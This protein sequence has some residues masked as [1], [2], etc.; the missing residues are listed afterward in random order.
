MRWK[1]DVCHSHVSLTIKCLCSYYYHAF[2]DWYIAKKNNKV[3]SLSDIW[4][5]GSALVLSST[6][7]KALRVS[8]GTEPPA[9]CHLWLW[10][11]K[12]FIIAASN[13]DPNKGP[14]DSRN[15]THL[16]VEMTPTGAVGFVWHKTV[17]V[18][19]CVVWEL[20]SKVC[21]C[22]QCSGGRGR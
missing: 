10:T 6:R 19:V 13:W 2:V 9:T 4:Y 1:T 5:F 14:G 22:L 15:K 11:K 3:V 21:G 17:C 18:C 7:W 20:E 16:W 8:Q 12:S